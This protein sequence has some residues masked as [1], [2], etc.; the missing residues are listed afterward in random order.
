MQGEGLGFEIRDAGSQ[1]RV[2]RSWW[3]VSWWVL[4]RWW[5]LRSNEKLVGTAFVGTEA[6]VGNE[7]L[8]LAIGA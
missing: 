7:Q 4:R 3:V 6:L 1:V 8:L 5:V 2:M